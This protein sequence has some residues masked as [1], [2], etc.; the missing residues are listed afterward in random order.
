MGRLSNG[1]SIGLTQVVVPFQAGSDLSEVANISDMIQPM[2]AHTVASRV[3]T[4]MAEVDRLRDGLSSLASDE[5]KISR[6]GEIHWWL[7]HAMPDNRGSAAKSEL[8]VRALALSEGLS[9]PPFRQGVVP[10]LESFVTSQEDF[11]NNY[12]SLFERSRSESSRP[13]WQD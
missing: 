12:G 1:T 13:G 8:T 4:I 3:S 9:L 5:E 7:S 6:L 10:D 2:M 11:R